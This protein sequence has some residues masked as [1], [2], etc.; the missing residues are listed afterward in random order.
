MT[1]DDET[2]FEYFTVN[3]TDPNNPGNPQ[4]NVNVLFP[5]LPTAG[6]L[7]AP[8]GAGPGLGGACVADG[9]TL[10]SYLQIMSN[11]AAYPTTVKFAYGDNTPNEN[12]SATTP[13]SFQVEAVS[14][15]ATNTPPP[16]ATQTVHVT[17]VENPSTCT[18]EG[19][20]G[21]NTGCVS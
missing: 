6:I 10:P 14:S 20:S 8:T 9:S 2:P 4:Q 17:N 18:G 16:S 1:R 7:C 21:P 5:T 19:G 3:A 11:T 12:P 13:N 15:A